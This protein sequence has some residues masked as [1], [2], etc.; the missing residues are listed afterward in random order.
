MSR[1]GAVILISVVL[2]GI[3]V[4]VVARIAPSD[5]DQAARIPLT[6]QLQWEP[7]AQ[8]L[9]FYVAKQ[10]GLYAAEGLDVRFLHG[11]PNVDPIASLAQK[12]ADVGLGTADQVLKWQATHPDKQLRAFGTVFSRSLAVF[13]VHSDSSIKSAADLRGKRVGVFPSYDTGSL[14][15][16][17]LNRAKVPQAEVTRVNFPNFA[18]FERRELDAFGAYLINEPVLAR[19]KGISIRY[20][21]PMEVGLRF[22]SDTLIVRQSDYTTRPDVLRRFAKSS[23]RGWALA[24]NN[25]AAALEDM[26]KEVGGVFGPGQAWEHQRGVANEALKYVRVGSDGAADFTMD[27]AVWTQM[28]A[29]L[30]EIDELPHGGVV[31][32]LCDFGFVSSLKEKR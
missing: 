10:R 22:Y 8:F 28:E 2:L 29:G 32:G 24:A 17:L 27:R 14:L 18:S 1:R 12:N 31:D 6:V 20:I 25:P 11:G 23:A 9:G 3:L 4:V 15:T 26:R 16:L 21:D 5:A 13:M 19:L 30:V 7:S